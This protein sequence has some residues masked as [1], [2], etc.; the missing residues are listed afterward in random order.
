MSLAG[1]SNRSGN[2]VRWL[3]LR[4]LI[5]SILFGALQLAWKLYLVQEILVALLLVASLML[6]LL[7]FALTF[8]LF[9]EGIRRIVHRGK[10]A[11]ARLA[12]LGHRQVPRRESIVHPTLPR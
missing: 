12:T 6:F 4:I 10:T 11:F 2:L 7:V 5:A 9:Q 8:V 1:N 3:R